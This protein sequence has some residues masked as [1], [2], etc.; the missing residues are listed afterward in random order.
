M[1]EVKAPPLS[2]RLLKLAEYERAQFCVTI[3]PDVTLDSVLAP[4][5][6]GHVAD[7]FAGKEYSKVE[8][9]AQD[10]K[11]YAELMVKRVEKQAVSMWVLAYTDL[12]AQAI[13]PKSE[14]GEEYVVSFAPKQRWRVVRRSDGAVVHK[15]EA[16]EADARAWLTANAQDLAG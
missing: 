8:C 16:T 7:R 14:A 9:R 11:W 1:A 13:R 15:D 4:E 3:P 12:D 5:F 10:N 2:P 6:W